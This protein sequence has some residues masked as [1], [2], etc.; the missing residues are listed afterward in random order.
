MS[1]RSVNF[2]YNILAAMPELDNVKLAVL[3]QL[4][5][6]LFDAYCAGKASQ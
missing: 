6:M 5:N 4:A 1:D 2:Y 3:F